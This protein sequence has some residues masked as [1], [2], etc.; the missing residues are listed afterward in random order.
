MPS[1]TYTHPH[2]KVKFGYAAWIIMPNGSQR[3]TTTD[4]REKFIKELADAHLAG[5]KI[6]INVSIHGALDRIYT[7][8]I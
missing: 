3:G 4:N 5:A 7:T 8:N 6:E 1:I 2:G